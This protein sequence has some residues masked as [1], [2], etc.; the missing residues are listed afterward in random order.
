MK[1]GIKSKVR[2]DT[3][4]MSLNTRL[5]NRCLHVLLVLTTCLLSQELDTHVKGEGG[6]RSAGREGVRER[7]RS[8]EES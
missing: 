6:E 1:C 7:D 4:E 8:R 3:K 2:E 5:E